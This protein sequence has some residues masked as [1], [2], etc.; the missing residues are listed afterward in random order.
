MAQLQLAQFN[1]GRVKHRARGA[2]TAL[3]A[4]AVAARRKKPPTLAEGKQLGGFAVPQVVGVTV[5]KDD[6]IGRR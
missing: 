4:P 3:A 6:E 5:R 1:I 2:A